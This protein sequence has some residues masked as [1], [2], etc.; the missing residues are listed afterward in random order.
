MNRSMSPRE[1][2]LAWLVGSAAFIFGNYVLLESASTA[3]GQLQASIASQKKQLRLIDSLSSDSAFWEKREAWLHA[4][5]PRLENP[6]SAAVQLL[7]QIKSV[8]R[9]HEVLVENP[10]IRVAERQPEY[11]SISVEVE[12]KSTWPPLIKFLHELQRGQQFI[13]VESANLKIDAADPTQMRGRFRI[14]R[15][16]ATR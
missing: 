1:R 10:V 12:T 2:K 8:A 6:E 13:A 4:Q 3:Y 7:D 14:A 5:Q 9:N 16:Y 15:W 11:I